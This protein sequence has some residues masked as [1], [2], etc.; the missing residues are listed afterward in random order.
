MNQSDVDS[1]AQAILHLVGF[2]SV[3]SG[4]AQELAQAMLERTPDYAQVVVEV[5]DF[6]KEMRVPLAHP[7]AIVDPL[8][9]IADIV[10]SG[11][12]YRWLHRQEEGPQGVEGRA[13]L[14]H[15]QVISVVCQALAAAMLLSHLAEQRAYVPGKSAVLA[16]LRKMNWPRPPREATGLSGQ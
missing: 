16:E 5:S 14:C 11:V 3:T 7:R 6:L 4:E 10:R 15:P 9:A 12:L 8:A 1:L 2:E 13:W